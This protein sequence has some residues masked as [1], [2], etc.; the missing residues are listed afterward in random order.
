MVL[1]ERGTSPP[2]QEFCFSQ[3]LTQ[4]TAPRKTPDRHASAMVTGDKGRPRP[5]QLTDYQFRWSVDLSHGTA[6]L[7]SLKPKMVF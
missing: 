4:L 5:E 3:F 7:A 1:Q 2:R 6:G